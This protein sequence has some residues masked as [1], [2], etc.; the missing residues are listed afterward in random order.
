[1]L[2]LIPRS[3]EQREITISEFMDDTIQLDRQPHRSSGI[4]FKASCDSFMRF[5]GSGNVGR[6]G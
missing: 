2:K 3:F 5:V 4:V 6:M 1:M